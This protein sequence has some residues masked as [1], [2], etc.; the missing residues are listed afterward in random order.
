ML[1]PTALPS[2]FHLT[3]K[4]ELEAMAALGERT[5]GRPRGPEEH[6]S[7]ADGKGAAG[8]SSSS[9][10]NL[11]AQP[12]SRKLKRAALQGVNPHPGPPRKPPMLAMSPPSPARG[13]LG[14]SG[15]SVGDFTP[16]M[17]GVQIY[18]LASFLQ[19]LLQVHSREAIY[20][21]RASG[22]MEAEERCGGRLQPTPQRPS[23]SPSAPPSDV[24]LKP[25]VEAVRSEHSDSNASPTSLSEVILSASGAANSWTR[26]TPAASPGRTRAG[27]LPVGAGGEERQT[28]DPAT[29]GPP[30]DSQVHTLQEELGE[31]KRGGSP[32]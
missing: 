8:S 11:R 7:E 1:K 22:V 23:Q 19:F 21:P 25:A 13:L 5:P 9:R 18:W 15:I 20:P 26:C 12:E 27:V 4:G 14:K 3:E 29:E 28:E 31:L 16:R 10:E 32:P 24:S 6:S 30:P 2:I 17:W